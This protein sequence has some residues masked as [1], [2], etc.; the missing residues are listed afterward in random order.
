MEIRFKSAHAGNYRASAREGAQIAYLVI[1]DTAG[2]APAQQ[3]AEQLTHA[4]FSASVH[5][6]VD[7][8]G[9]WQVV[10]DTDVAWHCGTR[11]TY[12]HP[13]CRNANSIGIA[14]CSRMLD[15]RY[16]FHVGVVENAVQLVR[17][18]ME[19]Y[20]IPAGR[21]LRHYD[22]THK[23]CPVPFVEHAA[24][25]QAFRQRLDDAGKMD[26]PRPLAFPAPV[27][28]NKGGRISGQARDGL[29]PCCLYGNQEEI[30]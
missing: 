1:H 2:N 3:A 7:E 27:G 21:V 9:V 20:A 28:Y 17:L 15:G 22:V 6:I 26:M 14:L 24:A 16:G 13:Y 18:L 19:C 12:Y 5:Y 25:W 23:T 4:V 11:G 30:T 10:R 29:S 8:N